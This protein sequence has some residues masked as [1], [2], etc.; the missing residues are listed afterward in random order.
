MALKRWLPQAVYSACKAAVNFYFSTL[1][2]EVHDRKVVTRVNMNWT[3]IVVLRIL[4][5]GDFP[6][7]RA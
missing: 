4:F 6:M 7:F 5:D 3:Q 1:L 2:T